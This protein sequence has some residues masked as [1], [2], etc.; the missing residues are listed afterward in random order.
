MSALQRSKSREYQ[1]TACVGKDAFAT[2]DLAGKVADRMRRGRC[3]HPVNA[4]RCDACR[5]W[6]VGRDTK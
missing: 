3:T 4:Y 2:R 5:K 6:H 1:L